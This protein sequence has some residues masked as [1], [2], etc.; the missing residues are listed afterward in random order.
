MLFPPTLLLFF[1]FFNDT[2][3]TEIY[4]LS[5]HDALPS[6]QRG[7]QPGTAALPASDAPVGGS[8]RG[9]A[10]ECMH[11]YREHGLATDASSL[12]GQRRRSAPGPLCPSQRA[13]RPGLWRVA[14]AMASVTEGRLCD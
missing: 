2:A 11:L 3:T 10:T 4:T 8:V 9:V 5:L 14:Q 1:F 13:V 6:A 12:A 7:E